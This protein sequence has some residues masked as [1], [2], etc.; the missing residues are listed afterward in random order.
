MAGNPAGPKV[1]AGNPPS[2]KLRRVKKNPADVSGIQ[3]TMVKD[4]RYFMQLDLVQH[5]RA[6]R[7]CRCPPLRTSPKRFDPLAHCQG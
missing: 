6:T 3:V 5:Q 4:F 1:S 2:L 7:V